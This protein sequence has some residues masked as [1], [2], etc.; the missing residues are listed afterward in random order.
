MARHTI[1][2]RRG[3]VRGAPPDVYIGFGTYNNE[4]DIEPW[5]Q[6]IKICQHMLYAGLCIVILGVL[7]IFA[8]GIGWIPDEILDQ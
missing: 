6:G 1:G 8:I 2:N 5:K 3:S 7:V 4:N